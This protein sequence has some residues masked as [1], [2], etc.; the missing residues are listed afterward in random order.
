VNLSF[1][2]AKRY[3]VAKKSQNVINIISAISVVGVA[4]GT[5]ALIVILSVFNGFDTLIKSLFSIFDP[6]L[7][8]SLVEGKTF[9]VSGDSRLK[10]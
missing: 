9:T 2:I 1:Y 4:T 7:E 5:M 6:E 8:I 3:L 10:R